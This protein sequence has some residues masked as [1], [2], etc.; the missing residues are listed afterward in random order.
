MDGKNTILGRFP[1]DKLDKAA[2]FAEEMRQKYYGKYAG[3]A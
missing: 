3:E 2:Q 1:L